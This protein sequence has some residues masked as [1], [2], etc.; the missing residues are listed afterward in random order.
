[1]STLS[2]HVSIFSKQVENNNFLGMRASKPMARR[3]A[4][5]RLRPICSATATQPQ[6]EETRRSGNYQ[7]SIWDFNYIQSLHT[8]DYKEERLLNRKEELIVEVK[9]LLKGKMEAAKQL[10]LIDDLQNLGLSY[11]FQDEIKN[12]LNCIYNEHNYFQNNISKVGDLHF[13]ALGFRLLRQHGFN[14]SQGV[15]ECFKNEEGSDFEE[16]LIGE[17]TKGILQLYEASFLLREGEDTLE[18]ARKFSTKYLRKKVDEGI[19]NDDNNLLSWI[20]H[21]LDLPLHWRIQRLEARWFLNAYSRRKDMNPLIFELS[22]LDFNII[23]ATHILELKEVSRWWNESGLVEKLPFVRDRLVESYFWAL[24]LFEAHDYGYQRKITTLIIALITATDDVYDVYGTLDELRLFTDA[25]RRWDTKSIDQLP[26]YMQLCYL[27][28]HNLVSEMAYDCLKH[29][30]FNSIPYFQRSWVSLG[31]GYL[32]EA[33]WFE[34]GYTPTLDEYLNNAKISIGSPTII[35]QVYL[36]LLNSSTDQQVLDSLYEYHNILYLSG[37]VLRLADDLGTSQFE[38][39]RGDVPKAL[40]CCMKDMKCREKEAEEHLRFLIR[41]AWKEINTTMGAEAADCPYKD[42][43][44]EAAANLGRAAQ[45]IYLEGDGHGV[46]HSGIH[47][48]MASSM[49]HPYI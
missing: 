39:K 31:E 41:E 29:K 3:V 43:L 46:Q 36:T 30:Q 17:D 33:E 6:V 49:F 7:A 5:T 14:V 10:E 25:I 9:K 48:Q 13:T 47:H 20:R 34:S 1:M 35:T 19:I 42:D 22:I 15:F 45:F 12:I 27:A 32:K 37:I 26:Y 8:P 4:S 2:M 11:F 28:L 38:L 18:L 44:F 23:Q 16:T 40:Q 24:G 21:S